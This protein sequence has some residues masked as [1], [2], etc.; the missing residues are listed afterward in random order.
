[1]PSLAPVPLRPS[2]LRSWLSRSFIL[3]AVLSVLA[4]QTWTVRTSTTQWPRLQNHEDDYYNLLSRGFLAG[5]L[6]LKRDPDPELLKLSDPYDP[7]K[8]TGIPVLHDVSY[9]RGKYYLYWGP[10]PVVTLFLPFR[11]IFGCDL[12][13]IYGNL[14]FVAVGF[15]A[16]ASLWLCLR[17]DFFPESKTSLA[18]IGVLA[19]GACG[20]TL[21]LVR[22]PSLWELPIASGHAFA[23]LGLA[24]AYAGLRG[25]A[26][27]RWWVLASLSL[28]LAVAS[29]PTY[30]VG[31]APLLLFLAWG[32][33]RLAWQTEK[34]SLW[35]PR[36][37][38][39]EMIALGFPIGFVV[40]GLL[41]YNYARFDH[42]F[43]FGL[44]YQM[45]AALELTATHFSP[46][47]ASFNG[48]LYYL[49]PAQWGR[50]FPFVQLAPSSRPQPEGYYGIEYV[51][52]LLVNE[53]LALLALLA[54]LAFWQRTV[55]EKNVLLPYV[56]GVATFY[57]AVSAGLLCFW[58]G[59]QRYMADFAPALI[60]LACIGLLAGE[61]WL[62]ARAPRLAPVGRYLGLGAAGFSVFFGIVVSFQLHGMLKY[63]SPETY[64][65]LAH[66]L[67]YPAYWLEK[68]TKFAHGP[69]EMD[70]RFPKGR[71]GQLEP[72]LSTGW[73]FFSDHVF[74]YYVN[75]HQ[76]RLGFDHTSR[77]SRTSQPIEINY[78]VLHH[79]RIELGSLY[80]PE[81]HPLFDG[82]SDLERASITQWLRLVLDGQTVLEGLQPFYDASPE[83]VQIGKT[84]ATK[85]YGERF[86]GQILQLK[87]GAYQ[88]L[89]QPHGSYGSI[90]LK[91]GFPLLESRSQPL[92]GAG[93]T[94]RADTLYVRYLPDGYVR[95]GYD[96]WGVGAWESDQVAIDPTHPQEL[97]IYLPALFAPHEGP[98][99]SP[100]PDHLVLLLD[101]KLVWRAQV[102]SYTADPS[103]VSLG[104]N[105][106]GSSACEQEFSGVIGAISRDTE[107]GEPAHPQPDRVELR[108]IFPRDRSGHREPLLVRGVAGA[109]DL[110]I[111]QYLDG[112]YVRFGIDHWG[113][114]MTESPPIKID[115]TAAHTLELRVLPAAVAS[116]GGVRR[117][118]LTLDGQS[119]W[120]GEAAFHPATGETVTIGA[121]RIG[122]STCEPAFSGA[123]L[124]LKF[125]SDPTP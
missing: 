45:S 68:K 7:Q 27:K 81:Q 39:S 57:L 25:R 108:L 59:T 21:S 95:F 94:G 23:M 29:R 56:S 46:R 110:F 103:Q 77:G 32:R 106:A 105:F 74:V 124:K 84:S 22:R 55:E 71:P 10:A 96:H 51:Y 114:G 121:N 18:V 16:L 53:P 90:T 15:V 43:E 24:C 48:F 102:P 98:H 11:V 125:P 38:W 65:R 40:V 33:A 5:R 91:L 99:Y 69:I 26:L 104:S 47:Y 61:R 85:A 19:L 70:L 58:A 79:L 88:F 36:T 6:S 82:K 72:L 14:L 66:A 100:I 41:A 62:R 112:D 12:P 119:I 67:N 20:M 30:V 92:V 1:M 120:S 115:F 83:S 75:D 89:S 76:L 4:F 3:L 111:V 117:F 109:A 64:H 28:G 52:G 78:D 2:P 73:E 49:S 35:P 118:T 60:L 9:Y 93:V 116:T 113:V 37:W 42:P 50:Y 122:A 123:I 86:T 8:R 87:R 31:V 54:P 101:Q 13:Q 97:Q 80:P 17:R 63:F 44:K 34:G 107:A